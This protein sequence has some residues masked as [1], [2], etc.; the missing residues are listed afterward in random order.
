M[1]WIANRDLSQGEISKQADVAPAEP[2]VYRLSGQI[3]FGAPA[4]RNVLIDASPPGLSDL[5]RNF[6]EPFVNLN[7]WIG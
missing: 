4:E 3:L 6:V 7:R 1:T 5:L 2:N